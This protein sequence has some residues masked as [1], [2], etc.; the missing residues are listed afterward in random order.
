M[1]QHP[2]LELTLARSVRWLAVQL[3]APSGALHTTHAQPHVSPTPG[4]ACFAYHP[5][6]ELTLA[7]SVRWL[8]VQ[9]MAP[10]GAL[11][12]RKC[13]SLQTS[14]SVY[15]VCVHACVRARVRVCMCVY[16]CVHACWVILH[17][18]HPGGQ[19][20]DWSHTRW[21]AM[22]TSCHFMPKLCQAHY[23]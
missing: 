16:A 15:C 4:V 17:I 6:L 12:A 23:D 20:N 5:Q 11:H 1:R 8:A 2:Q 18:T 3:M 13:S 21:I 14:R 7:R 19:R 9:F 10:S 22:L